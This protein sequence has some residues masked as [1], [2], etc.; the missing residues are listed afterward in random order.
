MLYRYYTVRV[1]IQATVAVNLTLDP[2]QRQLWL[3]SPTN[4]RA[5][6]GSLVRWSPCGSHAHTYESQQPWQQQAAI[7]SCEGFTCTD[8]HAFCA[9]PPSPPHFAP[10]IRAHL[11]ITPQVLSGLDV[12]NFPPGSVEEKRF[13]THPGS[14]GGAVSVSHLPPSWLRIPHVRFMAHNTNPNN[15]TARL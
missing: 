2:Q 6:P 5:V 8:A 13:L 7:Q 10:H 11:H 14:C 4:T 3:N 1:D 9:P 12:L 15:T